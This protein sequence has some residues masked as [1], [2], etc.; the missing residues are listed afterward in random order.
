MQNFSS[1]SKLYGSWSPSKF[2]NFQT[3]KRGFLEIIDLCLNLGIAFCITW[4][5]L[6]N[7]KLVR[8]NQFQINHASHL[9]LHWIKLYFTFKILKALHKFQCKCLISNLFS[10]MSFKNYLCRYWLSQTNSKREMFLKIIKLHKIWEIQYPKNF[11]LKGKCFQ[12]MIILHVFTF[13]NIFV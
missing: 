5:V 1:K 11:F 10:Q 8:E 6:P 3:K 12:K 4:L 2:S 13:S 7:Q 9:K